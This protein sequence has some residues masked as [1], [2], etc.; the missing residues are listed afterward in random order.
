MFNKF[1]HVISNVPERFKPVEIVET[2]PN[3]TVNITININGKVIDNETFKC[4]SC[5][6]ESDYD[7]KGAINILKKLLE[8][9]NS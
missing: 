8:M 2:T 6:C 7:L 3:I 9:E 4:G 5:N 1:Q